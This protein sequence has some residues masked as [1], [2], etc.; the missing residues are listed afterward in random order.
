MSVDGAS[1]VSVMVWV[2]CVMTVVLPCPRCG[3]AAE[4]AGAA[5]LLAVVV[6][7]ALLGVL[8]CDEQSVR[9][10]GEDDP[11]NDEGRQSTTAEESRAATGV[12]SGAGGLRVEIR[13][14]LVLGHRGTVAAASGN[15][16]GTCLERADYVPLIG[17]FVLWF[18]ISLRLR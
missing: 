1:C 7:G 16:M 15:S 8:V 11:G 6:V 13:F 14:V 3:G 4:L 9:F 18:R 10:I 12:R 2:P 5:E 17:L